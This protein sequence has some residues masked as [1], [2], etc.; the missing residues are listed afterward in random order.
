MNMADHE[1]YIYVYGKM[2]MAAR[3][4]DK[5]VMVH[6]IT[7]RTAEETAPFRTNLLGEVSPTGN[8]RKIGVFGG[9]LHYAPFEL[10]DCISTE[11]LRVNN[12]F[13]PKVLRKGED[14][15]IFAFRESEAVSAARTYGITPPEP[16]SAH[17]GWDKL[18]RTY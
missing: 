17:N 6:W 14:I 12:V 10:L 8:L 7:L 4:A 11:S 2:S 18:A 1:V 9:P 5:R 16:S 3:L 15:Y 13:P